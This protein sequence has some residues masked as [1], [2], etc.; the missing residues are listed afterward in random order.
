MKAT[1]RGGLLRLAALL[2]FGVGYAQTPTPPQIYTYYRLPGDTAWSWLSVKV[3][4]P[5]F[6]TRDAAG[7]AHLS[8]QQSST[9]NG[10]KAQSGD[11][12]ADVTDSG[13]LLTFACSADCTLSLPAI[14]PS[15]T[16]YTCGQ[17]ISPVDVQ[18]TING[19]G[20]GINNGGNIA[21]RIGQS[22]CIY[23]TGGTG[24]VYF[25]QAPVSCG[26]GT[27]CTYSPSG[28][29]VEVDTAVVSTKP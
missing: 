7:Q 13:K 27:S 16:W 25:G 1:K 12:T 21:L 20:N 10:V 2:I 14:P 3:D 18:L 17:N 8:I 23:T 19:N 29:S 11:Y 24:N 22:T 5:L 28:V 4:P 15:Q 26:Y 6:L 9:F